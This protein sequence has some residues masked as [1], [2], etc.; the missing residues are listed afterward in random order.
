MIV[1]NCWHISVK[2]I[3]KQHELCCFCVV[4]PTAEQI[5]EAIKEVRESEVAYAPI[6]HYLENQ[7]SR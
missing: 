2:S 3:S 1:I 4:P 5:Y 7:L 6:I